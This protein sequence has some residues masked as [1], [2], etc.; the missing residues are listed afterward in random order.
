M[1]FGLDKEPGGIIMAHRQMTGYEVSD[2]LSF[3]GVCHEDMRVLL[4]LQ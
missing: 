4:A 3:V 1:M 2:Y